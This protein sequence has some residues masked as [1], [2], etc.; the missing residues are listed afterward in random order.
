MKARR[1]TD[2]IWSLGLYGASSESAFSLGKREAVQAVFGRL[3]CTLELSSETSF[4]HYLFKE[5]NGMKKWFGALLLVAG[6]V[7][8]TS[9]NWYVG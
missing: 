7:A 3:A 9:A 5:G 1:S 2:C 4:L 8:A 6:I